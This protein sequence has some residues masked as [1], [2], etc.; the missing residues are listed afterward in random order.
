M[1]MS[2]RVSPEGQIKLLD[3]THSD[4]LLTAKDAPPELDDLVS[5]IAST[6]PLQIVQ[7]ESVDHW[8][9]KE[10]VPEY[11]FHGT[12]EKDSDR[13]FVIL[14]TSGSTGGSPNYPIFPRLIISRL[15]GTNCLYLW[16]PHD[17]P[18]MVGS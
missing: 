18:H 13:P 14:L 5:Q 7:V 12:L 2:P 11:P 3:I 6:R 4:V 17:L 16:C 9:D 15:S 10:L 1:L 8:F